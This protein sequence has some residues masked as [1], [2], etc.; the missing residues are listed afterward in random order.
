MKINKK[1]VYHTKN[2]DHE[3]YSRQVSTPY[4]STKKFFSFLNKKIKLKN[5][6]IIDLGCGSG[7]NLIHLKETYQPG[8]CFGFDQNKDLIDLAKQYSKQRKLKNLHFAVK[9]I[10]KA[11][12]KKLL[13][14][15]ID[16]V[17][18]MQTLSVLDNYEKTIIFAKKLKPKF[19]CVNSL[20]WEGNIDFKISVNFLE[21]KKRNI[22]KIN[23]Y[24]IYSIKHYI[25]FLKKQGYKKNIF[26][27]F[28]TEKN[29]KTKDKSLMGSYSIKLNGGS[30]IKSGPLILDWYFILSYKN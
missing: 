12:Q 28:K 11:S 29:L 3:Y 6:N 26:M 1:S 17:I 5:K 2:L 7:A 23:H 24:N 13:K 30:E 21:K 15:N 14:P 20:F 8:I 10:Q 19:I 22:K 25:Q 9:D 4:E 18:S 16:G 27:K